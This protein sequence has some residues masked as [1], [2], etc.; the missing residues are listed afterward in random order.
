MHINIQFK[1]NSH[2]GLHAAA[3]EGDVGSIIQALEDDEDVNK[4][5]QYGDKPLHLA[6]WKFLRQPIRL[7]MLAGASTRDLD[8]DGKS[9]SERAE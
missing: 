7:L 4:S 5:N 9:V 1:M 6:V 8:A 3:R 2:L